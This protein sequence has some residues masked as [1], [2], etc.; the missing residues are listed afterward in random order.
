[1]VR[2]KLILKLMLSLSMAMAMC[3]VGWSQAT[4]SIVG[5]V[6]DPSNAVIAGAQVTITSIATN[7]SQTAQ[8]N[9]AGNFEF[10]QLLPGTYKVLVEKDGFQNF[11][12]AEEPVTIG[13][14]SRIQAVMSIGTTTQTVEV[15]AQ[16]QLLQTQ[17]S[18]LSYGV[19]ETQFKQLP[20]NGRN[21][22]N[23][24]E[25]VPGVV[26]QGGV[27]GSVALSNNT[28]W[29]NYQIGGGTANQGAE[30]LDGAPVNISYVNAMA[31]DP[32]QDTIQEVQVQTNNVSPEYGRFAGGV[33]LMSTKSGTNQFHGALYEYVRNAA[34]NANTWTNNHAGVP[35]PQYTQNQYGAT[36]GGP[37]LR[38]KA[39]F[40]GSW[41]QFD[42]RQGVTTTTT[43]PTQ[44]NVS[45]VFGTTPLYNLQNS[46][47]GANGTGSGTSPCLFPTNSAGNYYI[48]QQYISPAAATMVSLIYLQPTNPT[49]TANNFVHQAISPTDYNNW[50]VRGDETVGKQKLFERYTEYHLNYAGYSSTGN[51]HYY[52][53]V[54]DSKQAVVGDTIVLSPNLVADV[55]LAALLYHYN[56]RQLQC[57]NFNVGQFGPGWQSIAPGIVDKQLPSLSLTGGYYSPGGPDIVDTDN[58]YVLSGNFT[59]IKGRHTITFGGED[60]KIEWDYTQ[61]N[62][63]SGQFKFN[64]TGTASASGSGGNAF[65]SLLVGLPYQGQFNE[66]L[67]SKAVMWYGGLYA[68]D[69]FR[70]TPKLTINAGL[71]WEQP[72][73]FKETHGSNETML[74]NL[75]Q[76]N[77]PAVNG[78][79]L[80]GGLA[81]TNSSQW[82]SSDWQQLHWALFSPRV[83]VAYSPT[84]RSTISGGFGISYLPPTVAF[85]AG[86]YTVP[87]NS[88]TSNMATYLT[89]PTN[90]NTLDNPYPGGLS[91]P[92]GRSQA[93]LNSLV[94]NGIQAALSSQPYAYYEQWNVGFQHQFGHSSSVQVT[95]VGS[96]GEN[97]PLFSV[98][99]DQLPDQYD[100]CGIDKTQPQ[101]NGHLLTDQVANPLYGYVT[102]ANSPIAGP[103]VPYGY[104]LKPHPQYLYMSALGPTVGETTYRALQVYAKKQFGNNGVLAASFTWANLEGTADVLSPWLES[105][106]TSGGGQ[107]VQDNTNINGN[108]T[109]P[110]EYSQSSYN[111]PQRLVVNYVYPLP[112]GKGGRFLSNANGVVNALVG[113]WTVNGVSTFQSGFPLAMLDSGANSLQTLYA[114][115]YAGGGTGAG[116]TRPNYVAGCNRSVSG[117]PSQRITGWFNT[118]CFVAPNVT[119]QAP[120]TLNST[121]SFGNEPRVDPNLRAQGLDTTDFSAMKAIPIHERYH[122]ELRAEFFNIF[123]WTQ[124]ATPNTAPDAGATFGTISSTSNNPRLAQ[125]SGRFTF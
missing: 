95:Y 112:F 35:R 33:L 124:F 72:G 109:N 9:T 4:G 83:G 120:G 87:T 81:L 88:G 49:A 20:L 46:T 27:S 114:V 2:S 53:Q 14:A 41:E 105:G 62:I 93:Y 42:L 67:I 98:N 86:P 123:N 96:R 37:L 118:S 108:S 36:L 51:L 65:A 44:A 74:L 1:M 5:T 15:T 60:R 107:G 78:Q 99:Q 75:P 84:D 64:N 8:S 115:G 22:L 13:I 76:P 59:W 25:L 94:G 30:Y 47:C 6:M 73:A 69:S 89:N 85:S 71:R 102:T 61:T 12:V 101:C 29:G 92:S 10:V 21:P 31:L 38:D 116:A 57:C 110:G 66:P 34:L 58:S 52:P 28:G 104:L 80:T 24:M 26:P 43:M 17:S 16:A 55:R 122:V 113:N 50:N 91:E 39:F 48:P 19:E 100:I 11:L 90:Y 7:Q 63:P 54:N 117:S 70:M 77:L 68:A 106:R 121:W 82:G 103:T 45:G 79:A 23:L 3:G 97:L 56:R 119:T 18:S 125:F 40:F 32:T 111:V